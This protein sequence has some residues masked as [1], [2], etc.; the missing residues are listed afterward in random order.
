MRG[1][2]FGEGAHRPG[3]MVA[4]ATHI[5]FAVT[6]CLKWRTKHGLLEAE[7]ERRRLAKQGPHGRHEEQPRGY[8][9]GYRIAGQAQHRQLTQLA[10]PG[11]LPRFHP[12]L[13][14]DQRT[15][16]LGKHAAQ[17]IVIADRRTADG[18]EQIRAV[19]AGQGLAHILRVIFGNAQRQGLSAY[20]ED[21][22]R[23]AGRARIEN[24]VRPRRLAR[25]HKLVAGREDGNARAPHDRDVADAGCRGQRHLGRVEDGARLQQLLA[26]F[27]VGSGLAH[28]PPGVG[29]IRRMERRAIDGDIFLDHHLIGACGHA[30][31]RGHT[32]GLPRCEW[33]IVAGAR[34]GLAAHLQRRA[35]KIL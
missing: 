28:M 2:L 14:E 34:T 8:H 30:C 6:I 16:F 23:Q 29:S 27:V 25:H 35:V 33:G 19:G 18:D 1:V 3:L 24:L 17:M 21:E 10:E 4:H 32:H 11:R 13:L 7:R 15:A 12:H 31:A 5:G 9:R 20:G 26:G 22:R